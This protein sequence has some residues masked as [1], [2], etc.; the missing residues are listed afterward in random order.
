MKTT[1]ERLKKMLSNGRKNKSKSSSVVTGLASDRTLECQ[2]IR[3]SILNNNTPSSVVEKSD[4]YMLGAN[5]K[6]NYKTGDTLLHK[7]INCLADRHNKEQINFIDFK[8]RQ[9]EVLLDRGNSINILN[10][11]N[12]TILDILNEP[13]VKAFWE[14]KN[15]YIA[16]KEFLE[17]K[18]AMSARNI[19]GKDRE[20]SCLL[21]DI[22][23]ANKSGQKRSIQVLKD[24]TEDLDSM[25]KTAGDGDNQ[26]HRSKEQKIDYLTALKLTERNNNS[27]SGGRGHN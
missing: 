9:I 16:M 27:Q 20:Y 21:N 10:N 19:S 13:K 1:T 18:G 26:R 12:K 15:S 23:S 24:E 14:E 7:S 25:E 2:G 6:Y 8:R 11:N 5:E 4:K 22:P 17:S 3:R